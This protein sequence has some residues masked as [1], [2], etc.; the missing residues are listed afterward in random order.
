MAFGLELRLPFL[1]HEL[2]EYGLSFGY[3]P[4]DIA[5]FYV[6]RRGNQADIGYA[7]FLDDLNYLNQRS[8]K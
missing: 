4:E 5:K 8:T 7:E 6:N 1:E 2:I 3:K